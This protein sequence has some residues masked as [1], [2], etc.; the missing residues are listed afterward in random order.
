[1]LD[2]YSLRLL[3]EIGIDVYVPR[4]EAA[5]LAH[6]PIADAPARS[7]MQSGSAAVAHAV[8]QVL[9]T[10]SAATAN[11]LIVCARDRDSRLPDD[12]LRCLRMAGLDAAIVGAGQIE[13]IASAHGL[14][15]LGE[16]LARSLGADMPAQRQNEVAWVVSSEPAVLAKS[17]TAKRAL[18]GEI[19]RLSRAQAQTPRDA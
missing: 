14:L 11:F 4:A 10:G 3:A 17:A 7:D 12:L 5:A 13:S 6:L 8:E 18:W 2:E 19:K 9:R 15:I 16:A 1:M